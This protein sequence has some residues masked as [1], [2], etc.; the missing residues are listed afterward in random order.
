MLIQETRKDKSKARFSWRGA[1]KPSI[2]S[3]QK[4]RFI[5]GDHEWMNASWKRMWLWLHFSGELLP[6][7]TPRQAPFV[8][9]TT[10]TPH[11]W[12]DG[13]LWR[14]QES[15]GATSNK[16]FLLLV[17]MDQVI[18]GSGSATLTPICS[19]SQP[20]IPCRRAPL[21]SVHVKPA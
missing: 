2:Q 14:N 1:K 8:K 10:L 3:R 9:P 6:K 4:F 13:I 20:H 19:I 18:C 17:T 11:P 16:Y 7:H 21:A 12:R 5:M 15:Y